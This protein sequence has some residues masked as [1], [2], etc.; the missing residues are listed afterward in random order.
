[1]HSCIGGMNKADTAGNIDVE[2]E[3]FTYYL[4]FTLIHSSLFSRAFW[5]I[6]YVITINKSRNIPLILKYLC[7]VWTLTRSSK[8][9]YLKPN[10]V[11]S[12][13]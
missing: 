4:S 10:D 5:S 13:T 3:I 6:H 1:M 8:D 9:Y 11:L 2:I 7:T 12:P